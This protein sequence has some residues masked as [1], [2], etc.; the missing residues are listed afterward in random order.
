MF[1]GIL[2]SDNVTAE[3]ELEVLHQMNS[4]ALAALSTTYHPQ[5]QRRPVV[6]SMAN[7]TAHM[8]RPET[9]HQ[10]MLYETGLFLC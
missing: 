7:Q 2:F 5:Y 9:Y 6:E 3:L 1:L 8:C 4:H 10:R